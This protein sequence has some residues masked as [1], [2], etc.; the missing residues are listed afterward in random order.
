MIPIRYFF[1]YFCNLSNFGPFIKIYHPNPGCNSSKGRNI[2]HS[3]LYDNTFGC[4]HHNLMVVIDRLDTYHISSLLGNLITLD[5]FAATFLDSK[6]IQVCP[7]PHS[8]FRY[9]EKGIPLMIQLHTDNFIPIP[10]IHADNTH[11]HPSGS[12]YIRF[13]K[14]DTHTLFRHKK[15]FRIFIRYLYFYQFVIFT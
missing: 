1:P 3:K 2:F 12:P 4:Y 15:Y 13:H 5:T 6:F 14:P 11:R 8:V 9:N 7:F 10:E